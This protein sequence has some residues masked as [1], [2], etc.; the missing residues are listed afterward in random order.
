[1]RTGE[2]KKIPLRSLSPIPPSPFAPSQDS[3]KKCFE[4]TK[5][6]NQNTCLTSSST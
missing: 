2:R 6:P 5:K 3:G 4:Q 1:M